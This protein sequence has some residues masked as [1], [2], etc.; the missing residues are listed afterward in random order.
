MS[1]SNFTVEELIMTAKAR[2]VENNENIS[3]QKLEKKLTKLL[4]PIPA[5][6][7]RL[8]PRPT[9]R[10]VVDFRLPSPQDQNL[11]L[12]KHLNSFKMT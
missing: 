4:T 10:H 2:N 8:R 12:Y 11:D 9:S 6:F 1:L 7:Q 3:R 5:P